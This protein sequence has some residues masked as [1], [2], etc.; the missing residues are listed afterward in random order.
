MGWS[1]SSQASLFIGEGCDFLQEWLVNVNK[2]VTF[3][4]LLATPIFTLLS[5]VCKSQGQKNQFQVLRK[6]STTSYA[7]LGM[8]SSICYVFEF[9][10][11]LE[12]EPTLIMEEFPTIC[13]RSNESCQV[14]F[15]SWLLLCQ[16]NTKVFL[17]HHKS[18]YLTL[19]IKFIEIIIIVGENN[20]NNLF[21]CNF[22]FLYYSVII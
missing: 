11:L 7:C 10:C 2:W 6:Y 15:L 22:H 1:N 18:L 3:P 20:F 19:S 13:G 21:V 17:P 16:N 5:G 8:C 4:K 9:A 14:L 12:C